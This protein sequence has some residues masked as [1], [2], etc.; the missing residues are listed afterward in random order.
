MAKVII[1][2]HG[3]RNKPSKEILEKWGVLSIKEGLQHLQID[4]DLPKFEVVYWADILYDKPLSPKEKNKKSPWYLRERY[5]PSRVIKAARIHR[6]RRKIILFFKKIIYAIFLSHDYRL[7]FSFI[8]NKFIHNNF[9]DLE[10]YFTDGCEKKYTDDCEKRDEIND[11]LVKALK[12][13][14]N[15]DIF[16]IAH[17]M[18]SIIAFD[19]LSFIVA[20]NITINTFVTIGSPLGAPFVVSRIARL[21]KSKN[22]GHIKLQ[23][24]EAIINKWY[25][26]SDISDPVALDFK[27]SDD[28]VENSKGV[29]VKDYIVLNTY[30]SNGRPNPHKSIGYLRTPEFIKALVKFIHEK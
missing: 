2:I 21:Y 20:H 16:L 24:P 18:G 3:L 10:V 19:V 9:K 25:N 11:R 12:K 5:I 15:D 23:T 6:Y 1:A 22:Q 28:F 27:L 7:R 17:S 13:H 26:F 8:S 30:K 14:K 29:K 4:V